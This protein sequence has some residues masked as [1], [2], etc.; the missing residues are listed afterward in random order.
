MSE[1][2]AIITGAGSGIGRAAAELFAERGFCVVATDIIAESLKWA[3]GRN[4]IVAMAGDTATE[5]ANLAW[6]EAALERWGRLDVSFL[7]AGIVGSPPIEGPGAIERFRQIQDVNVQGVVLGIRAAAPAM[8]RSGGGA[9]VA[10]AST[11][12]LGGDPGNWA[13]NASKAA[14]IN[15]VRAAAIDY[16]HKGIRINAVAPGPTITGITR[17]LV[18]NKEAHAALVRHVPMGRFADPREQA[19]VAWFLASSAASFITGVTIACDGGVSANAGHFL[20]RPER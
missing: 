13:Y 10:T 17:G 3:D 8:L 11:S 16:A 18:E 14:V 9:I 4:D 1:P 2:V 19:E 5:E 20:P 12:G 15:L 6:V 7:N